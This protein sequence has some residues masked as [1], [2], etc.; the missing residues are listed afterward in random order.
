MLVVAVCGMCGVGGVCVQ[1]RVQYVCLWC[2]CV[3]CQCKVCVSM[4]GD[5]VSVQGCGA[6][7]C[8]SGWS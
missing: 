4:Q 6:G 2:V 7:V 5:R 3:V 8:G 1:R